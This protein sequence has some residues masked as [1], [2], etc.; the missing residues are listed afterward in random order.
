MLP[1][2]HY[3]DDRHASSGRR[4]TLT[5][6]ALSSDAH[7][8]RQRGLDQYNCRVADTLWYILCR[9]ARVPFERAEGTVSRYAHFI[10]GE[11]W[12]SRWFVKAGCVQRRD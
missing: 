7:D 11:K 3:L 10:G 1:D 9:L 8:S 6:V 12:L 4:Q 5:C 2:I